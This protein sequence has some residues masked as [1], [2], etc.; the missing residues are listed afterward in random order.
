[1]EFKEYPMK[2]AL[3]YPSSGPWNGIGKNKVFNGRSFRFA[4]LSRGFT[5]KGL[6][7]LIYP[8]VLNLAFYGRTRRFGL[9]GRDPAVQSAISTSGKL[10][11]A[12]A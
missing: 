12:C 9:R 5:P 1:M 4:M 10:A 11:P 6:S 7:H 3:I 8:L 2:I